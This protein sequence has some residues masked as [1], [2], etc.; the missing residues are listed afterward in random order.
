MAVFEYHAIARSGKKVKGIVDA[1]SPIAAR[2]KLREQ[3]LFPTAVSASGGT[4]AAKDKVSA[5]DIRR[6]S[7]RDLGMMTRQ[8]SVLLH[9]GMPLVEAMTALLE[10]TPRR[11]LREAVFDV[12]DRVLEG[13]TLADGLS[14][15]PR[16]FSPLYVNMVRAGE[17]SGAL[18]QVLFRLAD[19]LERQ[20]KLRSKVLATLAYPCF[21]MLFA[22]GII[23]F[24]MVVIVPR[25]TSLLERRQQEL[26]RLT[27]VLIAT[28]DFIGNWWY[29]LIG[30]VVGT[31]TL[32]RYW[33]SRPA[34]RLRWDR[35]I[36]SIPLVGELQLK[37]ICGRLARTLGTMLE[38]GLTMMTALDV[39]NS[40][41]QNRHI[42]EVMQDVKA[43]VRRG[44]DLAVPLKEAGVFPPM[45]VQMAELGQ[46]S[47]ELE[48]SLIKVADIYDEDVQLTIDAL[49]SLLE[50][51]IIVFMGVFVGLLVLAILLPILNMSAAVG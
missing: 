28:S 23:S 8:L 47:G 19:I 4:A 40:V 6:V 10:Q 48:S 49:V 35:F 15:H 26:P 11:R 16:I 27:E 22:V 5:G 44:R 17:S 20:A 43:G 12:R 25:I 41:L 9:A 7:V 36:L 38:S 30:G 50:P 14:A 13:V 45:L 42:E 29:L 39:V 37:L 3:E 34:G 32:W 24:L 51:M 21:M 33:L 2:R 1:D 46:R 18:E 31:F